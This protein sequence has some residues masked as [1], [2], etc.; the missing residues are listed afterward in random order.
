[1]T[2]ADVRKVAGTQSRPAAAPSEPA[3][4]TV[5]RETRARSGPTS[6]V[7]A[8]QAALRRAIGGLMARSKREIPHY[9]L[10][11]TIDMRRASEWLEHMNADRS[12]TDRAV[13]PVLLLKATARAV[14]ATVPEMNGL[15]VEE[16]FEAN[17]AVHV[18]VGHLVPRWRRHRSCHTRHAHTRAR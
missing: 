12:I 5:A 4:T 6:D 1:M 3:V 13:M 8:K 9:Y 18:G 16:K 11:T 7:A 10:S 15:M 17:A 2:E 14:V